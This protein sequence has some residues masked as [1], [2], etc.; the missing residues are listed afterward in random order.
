M[1]LP[2]LQMSS[3]F[4]IKALDVA[5]DANDGGWNTP[6]PWHEYSQAVKLKQL[7]F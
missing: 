2:E 4:L 5:L 7:Q 3:T 1:T 6:R